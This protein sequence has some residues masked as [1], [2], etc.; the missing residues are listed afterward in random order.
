MQKKHGLKWLKTA[1][2]AF[3]KKKLK[4]GRMG[5]S[6]PP[7]VEIPHFFLTLPEVNPKIPIGCEGLQLKI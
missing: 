5:L 3:K 1:Q 7:F 4:Q 6:P 2:N